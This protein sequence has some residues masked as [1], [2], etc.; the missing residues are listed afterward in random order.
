MLICLSILH[1]VPFFSPFIYYI[2]KWSVFTT[3]NQ[4]YKIRR[5][6]ENSRKYVFSSVYV[7][8]APIVKHLGSQKHLENI[9]QNEMIIPE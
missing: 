3:I 1:W 9:I 8:R 4:P 2:F 5:K 7:H 6:M